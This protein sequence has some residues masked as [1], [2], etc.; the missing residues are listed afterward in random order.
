M[1]DQSP[2]DFDVKPPAHN[3][4]LAGLLDAIPAAIYTTDAD[5]FV[6]YYNQAAARLWGYRPQI[7]KQR[8]CGTW[9]ILLIDGTE[10]PHDQC[11]M[12]VAIQTGQPVHGIEAVAERPDGTR[13]PC[14]VYPT[15]L[16]NEAGEVVGG[17]NMLVDITDRKAAED[18]NLV[19]AREMHHRVNNTLVTV[20]SIMGSTLRH[21]A[22]MNEFQASFTARIRALSK[23]HALLIRGS[24]ATVSL[25]D[26]LNSELDMFADGSDGRVTLD[27]PDLILPER[28]AVP[29]G[30]AIHELATNA[31]KHGALCVLGGALSVEWRQA[32][33]E[34]EIR[35]RERNVPMGPKSERV[36]FGTRLL[37]EILP[38]QIGAAIAMRY[39]PDGLDARLVVPV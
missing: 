32:D 28:L 2:S 25:R 9:K 37:N 34:L 38:R 23:T 26:L 17:V 1:R 8:W 19:L 7:G 16:F 12:A 39:E 31:A 33:S 11:P 35:W 10:V 15:P 36:G 3:E 5:G 27:G 30:M 6:T 22:T 4:A 24:E 13:V 29:I 18:R 20:Q 21:T 14:A